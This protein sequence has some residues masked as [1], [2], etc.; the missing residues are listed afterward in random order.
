VHIN[1]TL[2]IESIKRSVYSSELND[3]AKQDQECIPQ[4]ETQHWRY[5]YYD[6]LE[7]EPFH[8]LIHDDSLDERLA[9]I[10]YSTTIGLGFD[11]N[12]HQFTSGD[13]KT[14]LEN[15][16]RFAG[17]SVDD[18]NCTIELNRML[19][20]MR[21]LQKKLNEAR[22]RISGQQSRVSVGLSEDEI[23]LGRVLDSFGRYTSGMLNGIG[24]ATGSPKQCKNTQLLLNQ[25][26]GPE[27]AR[28]TRMRFCWANF[29]LRRFLDP[30]LAARPRR[31]HEQKKTLINVGICVPQSCHSRNFEQNRALFEQLANSQ[32]RLPET[33]YADERPLELDDVFCLPDEDS[34]YLKMSTSGKVFLGVILLL[35]LAEIYAT[36]QGAIN[37]DEL[38]KGLMG[39]FVWSLD[40]RR[41]WKDLFERRTEAGA[42]SRSILNLE[43]LNGCRVFLCFAIALGHAVVLPQNMSANLMDSTQQV[44]MDPAIAFQAWIML[45]V[46]SFFVISS[47]LLTYLS[48]KQLEQSN[49]RHKPRP[50]VLMVRGGNNHVESQ[51]MEVPN[52]NLYEKKA[53]TESSP[54]QSLWSFLQNWFIISFLRYLR[55]VPVY[56]LLIW[57]ISS[58][59]YPH[60][61]SPSSETP[62]WDHGTNSETNGGS[63]RREPLTWALTGQVVF[64]IYPKSCSS[65]IW[66]VAQEMIF[67]MILPPIVILLAKLSERRAKM[68]AKLMAICI[69][70][71]L[72]VVIYYRFVATFSHHPV[73]WGIKEGRTYSFDIFRV[74]EP[75]I[76]A[77]MYSSPLHRAPVFLA[78]TLAGYTIRQ[79]EKQQY[80]HD[81]A[82]VDPSSSTRSWPWWFTHLATPFAIISATMSSLIISYFRWLTYS[83]QIRGTPLNHVMSVNA[84]T[85]V[86]TLWGI[87]TAILLVRMITDLANSKLTIVRILSAKIWLP[88]GKLCFAIYIIQYHVIRWFLDSKSQPEMVDSMRYLEL[89]LTTV[90]TSFLLSIPMFIMIENPIDKLVRVRLQKLL[91]PKLRGESWS[92]KR[93]I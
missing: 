64:E 51:P 66:S 48:I 78:G 92:Q 10:L 80:R 87:S 32:F 76:F 21:Q 63:C 71:I 5:K 7:P 90:T 41:S 2:L 62:M 74:Q 11:L 35:L 59:Y 50:I 61:G 89:S 36:I 46:N 70:T 13:P 27:S 23:R 67:A 77:L 56:F 19:E 75:V 72:P 18:H 28:I 6:E 37:G 22:K 12:I 73:F 9:N 45:L 38:P 44:E 82:R 34:D 39:H 58:I 33:L 1:D 3:I 52:A 79:W 57:F 16:R 91:Y 84:F 15:R 53:L 14:D 43:V 54:L 93:A 85:G 31:P 69:C 86:H 8:L 25:N 60:F 42:Q 81:A 30:G 68:F 4:R 40:L 29:D 24:R 49:E 88:I 47:L 20:S 55:L 17:S 65:T 83:A 26:E